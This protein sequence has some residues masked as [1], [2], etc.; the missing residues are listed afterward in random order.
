MQ[1][2]R[3]FPVFGF[4]TIAVAIACSDSGSTA[5]TTGPLATVATSGQSD[6]GKTS[7]GNPG[8]P[9]GPK[10]PPDTGSQIH[11]SNDP[12]LLGG[13]VVGMGPPGDSAN[14]QKVAGATVVLSIPADTAAGTPDKEI[15]RT[16]SGADGSFSLGTFKVGVYSLTVTPPAGSSF[17]S[18]HFAFVID[19]YSPAKVNLS[20]WLGRQ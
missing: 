4:A 9:T 2:K 13:T 18:S 6:T 15:T 3:V 12:R 8:N 19:T 1:L 20:V 10:T 7:P 14:Y 11:A 16:T 5:P 17:K